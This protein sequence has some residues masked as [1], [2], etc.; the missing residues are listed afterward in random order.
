MTTPLEALAALEAAVLTA[1]V[2]LRTFPLGAKVTPPGVVVEPPVLTP[3]VACSAFTDATFRVNLVV[4]LTDGKRTVEELLGLIEA[5]GDAI[6]EHTPAVVRTATPA[7]YTAA[8][9]EL[10]AYQLDVE[11]PL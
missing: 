6:E 5:V 11:Y 3:R 2:K 10:P 7:T 8:G 4:Q 1:S 9:V